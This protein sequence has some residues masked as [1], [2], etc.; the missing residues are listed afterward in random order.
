[1]RITVEYLVYIDPIK[2]YI[3]INK[4][5]ILDV[6][7]GSSEMGL[8]GLAIRILQNHHEIQAQTMYLEYL[9]IKYGYYEE[10]S[11][12]SWQGI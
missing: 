7:F 11:A 10:K 5:C 4:S 12:D 9:D 2:D 8:L 6:G 3:D 1:M